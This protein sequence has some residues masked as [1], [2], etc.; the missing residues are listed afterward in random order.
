MAAVP[1]W[2]CV[3]TPLRSDDA[4]RVAVARGDLCVTEGAVADGSGGAILVTAP[5]MRAYL[6]RMTTQHVD[7]KFTY[8]GATDHTAP[9]ASG[10]VRQQ[11]GLK[12]RAADA[13]NLVYVMWR[14]QPESKIVVS[15]K[16]NP[17]QHTS[18]EC[19][20]RGY[21]NLKP[22]HQIDAPI[23]RQGETH[24]LRAELGYPK[25]DA[26]HREDP[27]WLGHT[28]QQIELRVYADGELRWELKVEPNT[29][30]F[31]GPV[32]MRSDNAK[33]QIALSVEKPKDGAVE[34]RVPCR[35]GTG[36]S[37]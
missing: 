20:N 36:E 23:V 25:P 18:A 22:T 31:D 12:L 15:V 2:C 13:C 34:T 11:F 33:L 24:T 19:G 3:A 29:L 17:G 5:K 1:L 16:S 32:G 14:I 9:L 4:K 6:D 37:E 30:N 35:A 10:D 21:T 8:L 7:A 26:E 27:K 28:T